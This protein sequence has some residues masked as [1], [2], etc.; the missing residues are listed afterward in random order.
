MTQEIA[1]ELH[2]GNRV[3]PCL[4][5]RPA[6]IDTMF[7]DA[8]SRDP[9]ATA[10]V[11][12][13]QR[14]T[15][16]ALDGM[17]DRLAAN[18]AAIGVV[19][20]DRIATLL[21]N[22]LP[23]IA[24]VLACARAG[25][26]L[27][28]MNTRQRRP[29][30]EYMLN[31]SGAVALVHDAAMLPHLPDAAAVPALRHCI[32]VESD[33]YAAL[34][35]DGP[36]ARAVQ[37][38]EDDP[39]CILYTSGTTG[40]PKGA[41]LTHL[42]VVHSCMNYEYGLGLRHGDRSV[43]AVPASHVTGLIAIILAM[44]RVGGCTVV[45][46]AFKARSYLEIVAAERITYSLMVPAMYN[47]CLRDPEFLAFDLSSWRVGG[48][49]GAPMPAA[50][51]ERMAESLP[52]LTLVNIYGS[53]ETTSPVTIMPP[54][55]IAAHPESVGL[56]LPCCDIRVMDDEGREVPRG[57]AGELWIAGPMVAPGYWQ[58]PAASAEAFVHGY[59]R[60][61]D[62]GSIDA[63]GFVQVFDRKKDVV[64]RGGYKIYSIEVE[65]VLSHMPNVVE[66]AVI[67]RPCP[68][69]GERLEAFVV[70]S[71]PEVSAA[72]VREFCAARLSDYKVP[73]FVTILDTPLPRN[74]NGKLQ[75]SEIR[76][77]LGEVGGA[78]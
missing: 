1:Y 7:R 56:A 43:L 30:T 16:A 6:D 61:G 46:A 8:V 36:P 54:G 3:V 10:V 29:E 18:L 39:F 45:M 32:A 51:I 21:G 11:D 13:T 49:G 62:I 23:G 26:I 15:F 34:L 17:V 76:A 4:R 63:A 55:A 67:A 78:S 73:D 35:A 52:G 72:V 5:D 59:W 74:A 70:A 41:V 58:D 50:T 71:S 2:Y 44:I 69:L 14:T 20:G 31:D 42:G 68:V 64:N 24:L 38:G 27:V 28:A 19:K 40:R 47:L 12:G 57:I 9:G 33:A 66:T 48:F 25:A 65:N 37:V 77:R 22:G 75:K 60:S 53:T